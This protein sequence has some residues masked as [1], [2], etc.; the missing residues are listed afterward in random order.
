[1]VLRGQATLDVSDP[2]LRF[3]VG[4][5]GGVEPLSKQRVLNIVGTG[6]E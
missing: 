5:L 6:I 2:A 3:E 4:S 1:M